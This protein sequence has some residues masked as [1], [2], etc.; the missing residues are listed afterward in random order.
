MVVEI[1]N[2]LTNHIQYEVE[3]IDRRTEVITANIIA[4]NLLYQ[5]DDDGHQHRLI[6]DI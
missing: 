6:N 3:Y 4:E 5:V 2:S 1:N